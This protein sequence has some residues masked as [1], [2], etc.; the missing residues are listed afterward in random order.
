MAEPKDKDELAGLVLPPM[1]QRRP[2]AIEE[3]ADLPDDDDEERPAPI[4]LPPMVTRE[5]AA[6]QVQGPPTLGARRRVAPE[7]DGRYPGMT[8]VDL[9]RPECLEFG[10]RLE[11]GADTQEEAPLAPDLE[12]TYW[13]VLR[14]VRSGW[15]STYRRVR[16]EDLEMMD[17]VG[18]D[19][20]ARKLLVDV[21]H[22]GGV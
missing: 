17:E 5:R 15:P 6:E 12:A 4:V 20:L 13:M 18:F 7:D 10:C 8:W 9:K 21:H 19:H 3:D 14:H 2:V 22:G 11:Y 1:V 16:N